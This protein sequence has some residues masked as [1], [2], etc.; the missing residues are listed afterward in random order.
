MIMR[1]TGGKPLPEEVT[2]QIID[3]TDGVPLFIEE[4]TKAVVES[5][6]LVDAG[7]RYTVAGPVPPLAIPTTLQGSLLARLDHLSPVREVAQIAAALGRRFSHELISAIAGMP[8]RQVDDALGQLV[9]AEL[10]FRRGVP[11]DAEYTFKHALV[12]DTAYGTLLRGRRQ[13]LHARITATLERQFPEIAKT[14]PEVLARHCTEAGL[15][16]KAIGYWTSAARESQALYALVEATLQARKGLTLLSNLVDGPERWRNELEL[17]LILAW[18]EFALKWE[19][20]SEVWGASTRARALCDR[21]EDRS[22]LGHV[23]DMQGQ[24]HVARQEYAAALR[25]AKDL[26]QLAREQ[27][28]AVREV[29]AHQLMGRTSH[30]LGEFSSAVRHF[31]RALSVRISEVNP[32]TKFLGRPLATDF[33]Q[34]IAL[35]HLAVDLLVL[36]HLDQAVVRR[37]QGLMLARKTNHR[38]IL[39]VALYWASVADRLRRAETTYVECLTE[40]AALAKQQRFP[41]FCWVA[42]LGFATILSARGKAEEGLAR[43]RDA[44]AEY[45]TVHGRLSLLGLAF[46]C[47][48]AGEVDEALALLDRELEVANAT[49]ERFYEAELHRFNGE[50][51]LAH[52]SG[53]RMEAEDCYQRALAVA[54]KQ[55]AKFWELRASISLARLWRDQGKR[56]E[57]R[58]LLASI[59]GWFTEGLDTPV[60]REAK[61]L[62]DEL[63]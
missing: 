5:D 36:G 50:W 28:H 31:E 4:L 63:A 14:R 27:N 13:Q 3:R 39:A 60:L 17:Q 37:N 56:R 47:E 35:S 2:D 6:L 48:R 34:A 26:L 9:R 38:Y 55:Q 53:R 7:D 51:L 12:Q 42:E 46:C 25:V 23:L 58:D 49:G 11:P 18:A 20:A 24:Y 45:A 43:A 54:R 19:G 1:V 21:L 16:E 22:N 29:R 57:A 40:L 59:Y 32:S 33:G 10:I 61:A 44:V 8:Q 52:R 30:L 41:L 62:L 15:V